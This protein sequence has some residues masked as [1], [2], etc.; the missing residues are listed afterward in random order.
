MKKASHESNP[1][2]TLF[3]LVTLSIIGLSAKHC[4]KKYTRGGK[5]MT[6]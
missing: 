4:M 1:V 5:K 3:A 6:L 2:A